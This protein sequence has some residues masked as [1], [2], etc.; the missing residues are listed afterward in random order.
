MD[1]YKVAI[2]DDDEVALENL[3]FE[4]GK[5][6]RFFLKGTARN[7]KQGKK[8]IAKVQPDLLFLDVELPDMTGM[9]LLQEIR[10]SV[11]WNM[12]IVFY[13]AYDKYMIYAIRGVAFDY[14]LK[15]ID[16]KELEGIIDRFMKKA[17]ESAAASLVIPPRVYSAGEHTFMIS[18]PINDLR[19]L[20]SIDIGFFRY[21]SDRKLWEVVLNNQL[22]LL[23]KKNTTADHIK[24]YDSCFVQ[25]HQSYIININY[26]M[27]I[28]ENRCVMFPPFENIT[29]LQVSKKFRKE[30]QDRFYLL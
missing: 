4:L 5:D 18:T 3:S 28:K 20:R 13:T 7:G 15:P 14:L 17:E 24:G 9:E 30:L 21:N 11:S 2:V 10:D 6:A 12:R 26:L 23:L 29:E 8:L 16:K 19:I 25:I 22:P 1:K 27:M